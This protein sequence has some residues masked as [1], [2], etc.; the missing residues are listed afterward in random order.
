MF[1]NYVYVKQTMKEDKSLE[2]RVK[3]L[4][5]LIRNNHKVKTESVGRKMFVFEH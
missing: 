4:E 3:R 2:Y 1:I 5:R